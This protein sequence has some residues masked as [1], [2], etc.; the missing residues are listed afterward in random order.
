MPSSTAVSTSSPSITQPDRGIACRIVFIAPAIGTRSLSGHIQELHNG[1]SPNPALAELLRV[2]CLGDGALG[3]TGVEIQSYSAFAPSTR[4]VPEN[5][6]TLKTAEDCVVPE[7]IAN[8]QF[9]S[10]MWH[11]PKRRLLDTDP[12]R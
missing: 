7:D 1:R 9:T 8:L 11:S 3:R 4:S 12:L 2:V 5:D 6:P 10:G